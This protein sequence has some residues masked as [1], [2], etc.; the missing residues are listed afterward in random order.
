MTLLKAIGR[1]AE[2][3]G[4]VA[5]LA[6]C[7]V[8]DLILKRCNLDVD[9]VIEGDALSFARELAGIYDASLVTYKQFGTATLILPGGMKIDVATSRREI[10][11][12]S[13]ALPVVRPGSI[14]EDLFRRDFT[15]NAMAICLNAKR[16]GALV[17]EYNGFDD[18]K[19]KTIRIL[20]PQSFMDDPTRILRAVRF[21]QRFHFKIEKETLSRLKSALKADAVSLVKP[22]RYFEEFKKILIEENPQ[23]SL[24]RLCELKAL[25]FL[26]FKKK[27]FTKI[28]PAIKKNSTESGLVPPEASFKNN[29][30]VA[31]LFYGIG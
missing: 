30:A 24:K 4:V 1:Y 7:F 20:H 2:N 27:N 10:Y 19:K 14:Q 18:L 31:D 21:E 28:F 8:R 6:G 13:G 29:R 9:I 11:T 23:L 15:I 22:P 3:D 26:G 5:Y 17:D 12:E 16:F 25:G